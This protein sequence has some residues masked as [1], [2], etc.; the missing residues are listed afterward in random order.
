[1][2]YKQA[3]IAI[4]LAVVS[5]SLAVGQ[6]GDAQW[7]M[8]KD[9]L[10]AL[11]GAPDRET[12]TNI[13]LL[14]ATEVVIFE[15][16]GALGETGTTRYQFGDAGLYAM[17]MQWSQYK[18]NGGDTGRFQGF[19]D[20]VFESLVETYGSDESMGWQSNTFNVASRWETEETQIEFLV[21]YGNGKL[22]Y[23]SLTTPATVQ[24]DQERE[25]RDFSGDL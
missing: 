21:G 1:M 10:R 14:D 4:F 25:N 13:D 19:V 20:Q 12:D 3:A 18:V 17:E 7:G 22:V 6:A 5:A 24:G 2:N 23:K 9:D 16:D 8:S 15:Y 11:R